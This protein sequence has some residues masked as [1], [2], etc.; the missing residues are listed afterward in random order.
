MRNT[1]VRLLI[2]PV[3]FISAML[4]GCGSPAIVG[5]LVKVQAE[6]AV[7]NGI[8][9]DQA[10]YIAT[11]S[12][13][14]GNSIA[15][16]V[17]IK[18]GQSYEGRLICKD[19][20][21]DL[22]LLKM[23]AP[24]LKAALLGDSDLVRQW[25]EVT[26]WGFKPGDA[27]PIESK[28]SVTSLPKDEQIT[29]LQTNAALDPSLAG[30]AVLNKAGEL[31][32]MVSWNAGQPGREGFAL[33]SNEIQ[34]VLDQ[35]REA[36]SDSLA[37]APID[38][39]S[40]FSDR[41]VIS[42][43]TNRPATGQ[44]EFGLK[45]SYGNKTA[46]D[47][48]MLNTHAAVLQG[49]VPK[50]AYYFRVLSVDC[51]GNAAASK[52]YT[53]TTT[54]AGA[55]AGE[56]TISNVD[57]YDITST[58]AS[59]RWITSKPATGAVNYTADKETESDS[60]SDDNL[61]YEHKFRLNWLKP[62]TRYSVTIRSET[63]FDESARQTLSPFTTPPTS[64]V[65]CKMNCR[66]FD[67]SF[68][69]LQGNEFSN[70]DIAGKKVF[71]IFTKTSC[72]TCMKQALFLND[73]YR[74]WPKDS[75]MLMFMVA[76]SEKQADVEEWIKRY[77]LVMPVYMDP[78]AE[79]VSDCQFRTIPT[80]LFL[81]TGSVIRDIKSGGFGNKKDMEAALKYFYEQER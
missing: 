17:E 64:P 32:G 34:R 70:K 6:N 46:L 39:P 10:G 21:R 49:L 15:P 24:E 23:E 44:I 60:Q 52:G 19:S 59:V 13:A 5:S 47:T 50:T 81:D 29:Y 51:C 12:G 30:S 4:C 75:D 37:V 63:D 56:F 57:V 14:L 35:A 7:V 28:G 42:W 80:A 26:V 62:Q 9:I 18:P 54:A 48:T 69:T 16:S 20:E 25:D 78:T 72:P 71:M 41:A 33:T 43:Q 73:V 58:A 2:L 45:D 11:G 40:V 27:A 68:K 53:L 61:V 76:S 55:Q 65:G 38:P 3:V 67:F 36:E 79:L 74:D 31:I 77:G 22:A 1:A 66:I 8:I